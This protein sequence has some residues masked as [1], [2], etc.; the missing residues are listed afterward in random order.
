MSSASTSYA[1]RY[2][3]PDATT[4]LAPGVYVAARHLNM[5]GFAALGSHQFVFVVLSSSSEVSNMRF[6]AGHRVII[7]GAYDVNGRLGAVLNAPS[8][9]EALNHYINGAAA[10]DVA[11]VPLEDSPDVAM[12]RLTNNYQHYL[13]HSSDKPITYPAKG[14][15]AGLGCASSTTFNSNS[16]AQSL[17]EYTFG[18]GVVRDDFAGFDICHGNRIPGEYFQR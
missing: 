6:V 4:V 12:L 5:T 7:F 3:G 9:I 1:V 13:I 2:E 18:R 15:L 17:V 8:D 10:L 11:R 14:G 16:W